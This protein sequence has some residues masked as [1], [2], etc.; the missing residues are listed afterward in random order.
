MENK[1]NN[2]T[3]DACHST[4]NDGNM[5]CTANGIKVGTHDACSCDDISC[6]TFQMKA[7]A[8]NCR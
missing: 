2:I 5:T 4:Y 1:N 3:C 6:A 8:K 7:D